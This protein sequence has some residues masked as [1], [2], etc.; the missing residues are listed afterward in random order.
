MAREWRMSHTD[1][2]KGERF[3]G[4]Q[5]RME[6][7]WVKV[8]LKEW[9]WDWREPPP[10]GWRAHTIVYGFDLSLIEGY[11][12]GLTATRW[13][14]DAQWYMNWIWSFERSEVG[15]TAAKSTTDARGYMNLIWSFGFGVTAAKGTTDGRGYIDWIWS[16]ERSGVGV[17]AA[18]GTTDARGFE[19]GRKPPAGDI[20]TSESNWSIIW[21]WEDLR[22]AECHPQVTFRRV[23]VIEV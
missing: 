7:V 5:E 16:F 18:K 17:A 6:Y 14:T 1:S 11:I 9:N 12:V 19:D 23:K 2:V 22:M 13:M 10:V 3:R 21:S 15:T 4:I 20:R 8:W